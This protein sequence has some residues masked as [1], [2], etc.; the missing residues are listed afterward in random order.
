[1]YLEPLDLK[2][3]MRLALVANAYARL[4]VR[5]RLKAAVRRRAWIV[6]DKMENFIGRVHETVKVFNKGLTRTMEDSSI[7]QS[8]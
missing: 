1:M 8:R 5:N 3:L 7:Q 6:C 4:E 2:C